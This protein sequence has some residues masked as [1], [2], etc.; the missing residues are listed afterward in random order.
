VVL[1]AGCGNMDNTVTSGGGDPNADPGTY[2]TSMRMPTNP[3][4]AADPAQC[5]AS[6]SGMFV[7]PAEK[8]LGLNQFI[9]YSQQKLPTPPGIPNFAIGRDSQKIVAMDA[10]C[11][12]L[13]CAL[14]V[15]RPDS[16]TIVCNCHQSQFSV[17]GDLLGGPATKPLKRYPVCK[18]SDG[19]LRIDTSKPY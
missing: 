2:S 4:M 5:P 7:G 1:A 6:T 12:H 14:P 17:T 16:D 11:T 13:G 3:M 18:G 15:P 19:L 10:T 9:L 8:D